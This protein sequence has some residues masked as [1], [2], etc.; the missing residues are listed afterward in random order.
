MPPVDDYPLEMLRRKKFNLNYKIAADCEYYVS[1][2]SQG[3][4]IIHIPV[5]ISN[6]QGNGASEVATNIKRSLKERKEILKSNFKRSEY[7][8]NTLKYNLHGGAIKL[9]LVRQ[10]WFYKVYSKLAKI[11]YVSK[12]K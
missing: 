7:L 10:K 2:Y 11:Y 1:S 6:Y 3:C 9:F 5:A 4:Q 8:L 12:K